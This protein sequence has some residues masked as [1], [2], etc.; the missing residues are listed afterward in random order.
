MENRRNNPKSRGRK[1]G[2]FEDDSVTACERLEAGAEA[3]YVGSVP[4]K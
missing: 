1:F 2:T 3:K 4:A